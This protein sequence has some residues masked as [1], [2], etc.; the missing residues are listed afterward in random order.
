MEANKIKLRRRWVPSRI[1]VN[2]PNETGAIAIMFAGALVIMMAFFAL[3]LDLSQLYNR[4]MELQNVADTVALAAAHELDGTDAGISSALQKASDRF[5]ASLGGLTYQYGKRKLN[6]S[7]L[8]ME[9]GTSPQGPW[10]PAQDAKTQS[11]GLLYVKV[12]T[13]GLDS[14]YGQV[15]TLFAHFFTK[16]PINSTNARAVAGRSAIRVTPLGICA[17]RD[18]AR[19]NSGGELEEYGFRRGVGYNLL[20]LDRPG[21]SAGKTF[22]VNPLV[23]NG[24]ITDVDTLAPFVCTGTMAMVRL[25]GGSVTVSPSFPLSNLYHH[26]NSRFGSYSAPSAA[27][28]ARTAPA[29]VNVKEYLFNGGALWMDATPLGQSA[30][31]LE[32]TERRWTIAGPS[33]APDGTTGNQFG[34]LWSYAKAARY[35][36]YEQA[37]ESEPAGGYGTFDINAWNTLY[38]PGKPKTSTTTPYPSSTDKPTPYTQTSGTAF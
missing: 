12:E 26:L 33:A 9:F 13:G 5:T 28:D 22:T 25:T 14:S 30:A 15:K 38:N 37:G 24:T 31:L 36:S 27:C 19:R 8:A 17:M 21:S 23:S 29:D 20:D 6:W 4:K 10:R 18:E 1:P 35:S 16:S 2:S 11:N 3:A 34:P 32:S 7:D